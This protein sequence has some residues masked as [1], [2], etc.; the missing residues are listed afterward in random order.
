[1]RLVHRQAAPVTCRNAEIQTQQIYVGLTARDSSNDVLTRISVRI[2][3][4]CDAG[5]TIP[6]A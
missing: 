3:F 1:M 2:V 6:L 4:Q 5:T